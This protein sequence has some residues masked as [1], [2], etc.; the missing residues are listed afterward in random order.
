MNISEFTAYTIK[1]TW[2]QRDLRLCFE[3]RHPRIS[4]RSSKEGS[5]FQLDRVGSQQKKMRDMAIKLFD[6]KQFCNNWFPKNTI[7]WRIAT[8]KKVNWLESGPM[9]LLAPQHGFCHTH[10]IRE[11]LVDS[12]KLNWLWHWTT[13]SSLLLCRRKCSKAFN[14]FRNN[15][16]ELSQTSRNSS[17]DNVIFDPFF[18]SLILRNV[19]NPS[20]GSRLSRRK[21]LWA[22]FE[23]LVFSSVRLALKHL[24]CI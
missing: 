16:L 3:Y 22:I 24:T 17:F 21:V 15:F 1:K 7:N 11:N 10:L 9:K 14:N 6:R 13:C 8:D 19:T 12:S 23:F 18:Q 2:A 5:I 4:L 20:H